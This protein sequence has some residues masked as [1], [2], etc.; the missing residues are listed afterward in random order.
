MY[1]NFWQLDLLSPDVIWP[2]ISGRL[3]G[4]NCG[5]LE[6]VIARGLMDGEEIL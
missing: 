6:A 2:S 3:T 4:P 5:E 1:H